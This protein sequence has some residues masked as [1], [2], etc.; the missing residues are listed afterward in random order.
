MK[1][2]E[3]PKA[4]VLAQ[5]DVFVIDNPTN[6][7]RYINQEDLPWGEG[8]G[9]GV[10]IQSDPVWVSH[11]NTYRGKNLGT[12]FTDEQKQAIADGT[13]NDLYVGDY[14]VS[15]NHNFRIVDINYFCYSNENHL[16]ICPD[17][18]IESSK[19]ND[20]HTSS[21]GYIN[22][23]LK[24]NLKL[25]IFE[26]FFGSDHLSEQEIYLTN[27]APSNSNAIS[28]PCIKTFSKIDIPSANMVLGTTIQDY[29]I[30][31]QD[32][33]QLKGFELNKKLIHLPNATSNNESDYETT[34]YWV[35][36]V[37]ENGGF[38][39]IRGFTGVLQDHGAA[40]PHGIRPI[41]YIK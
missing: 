18:V 24:K 39:F 8:G 26:T 3:Y 6:G 38:I 12:L 9:E 31:I 15:G 19:F 21:T 1:I 41:V 25:S 23:K 37:V 13:F 7:T 22:S 11:R 34:S 40:Y 29:N 28:A 27:G 30:S 20:T 14:W 10:A 5:D 36:D 35:R 2:S 16:V 32:A 17:S 4:S 33:I